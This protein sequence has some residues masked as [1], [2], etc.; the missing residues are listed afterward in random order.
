MTKQSINEQTEEREDEHHRAP[1]HGVGK[2]IY[3]HASAPKNATDDG[4]NDP[5]Q[6]QAGNEQDQDD[7]GRGNKPRVQKLESA[8]LPE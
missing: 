3:R 6:C 8:E 5:E 4:V 1:G 2:E 7:E